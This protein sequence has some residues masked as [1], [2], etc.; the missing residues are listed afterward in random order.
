MRVCYIVD[1]RSPIAQPWIAHFCAQGHDVCVISTSEPFHHPDAPRVVSLRGLARFRT[2]TTNSD[3]SQRSLP[4]R[5][6]RSLSFTAPPKL[7]SFLEVG[8]TRFNLHRAQQALDAFQPNLVHVMRIPWEGALA[9]QL[10][11]RAPLLL[12]IWGNDF[13][14]YALRHCHMRRIAERLLSRTAALHADCERDLVLAGALGFSPRRPQLLAPSAGG[15]DRSLFRHWTAADGAVDRKQRARTVINPRGA[16]EY[17]NTS[18]FLTAMRHV[19]DKQPET[20]AV[21]VGLA[22]NERYEAERRA[23]ALEANVSFTGSLSPSELASAFTASRV[24]VSPS[25]HDGTPNSFLEGMACGAFPVV[26]DIPSLRE[27]VVQGRNGLLADPNDPVEL[28]QHILRALADDALV[29]QADAE[30]QRL[31][32]TRADRI[33]VLE[34]MERLY[35]AIAT[36]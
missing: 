34:Q 27:W 21:C 23:Y 9:S 18:V 36:R 35:A 5:L 15:V 25:V 8:N 19:V 14:L 1:Y 4:P 29:D 16:R 11:I 22:G 24:M 30:N 31:I 10:N 7:R 20:Q 6:T 26:G 13:T 3:A 32:A 33:L 17:V 12:S 2:G 28:A